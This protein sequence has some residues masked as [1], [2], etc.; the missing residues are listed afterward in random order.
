MNLADAL[1]AG[2]RALGLDIAV[3]AQQ[4]ML[5]YLALIEK[6]N[7]AYNLT[8]VREPQKM[9]THHLLDSL[10]VLP[11]LRGPRVLDVGTGAGLP[12]IPLA[13]ARPD[14]QFTLLDSSHKKTTFLRQAV[15]ELQLD[16]VEVVC[17]RVET[18]DA[19]QPFDTVVSRA[20]SDVAEFIAL[21]G[22]LC[23]KDGVMIAMKGVYP[24]EE[25]AQLPQAFRLCSVVPLQVP[26]L[27]AERHAAVLQP[28]EAA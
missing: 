16:N 1:A 5:D 28:A 19:P 9:L 15:I 14:W 11:H 25:L 21:A 6:W 4:R 13:L 18:W 17:A 10:A 20:F 23:A 26:G 24:H 27:G 8:A 22:R 2:S 12:G 3:A 7:K